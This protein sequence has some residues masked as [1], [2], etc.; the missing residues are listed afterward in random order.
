MAGPSGR[1]CGSPKGM[2][3]PAVHDFATFSTASRGPP[4]VDGWD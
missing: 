3:V 1:A 2:L 4:V